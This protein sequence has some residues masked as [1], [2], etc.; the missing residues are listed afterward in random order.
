MAP[1]A[2][3]VVLTTPGDPDRALLRSLEAELIEAGAREVL[4]AEP[5]V[6]QQRAAEVA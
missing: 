6:Q 2:D 1:Y 3:F 4:V 5:S